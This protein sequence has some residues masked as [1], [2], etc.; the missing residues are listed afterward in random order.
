MS[1]PT[2]DRSLEREIEWDCQRVL[3]R[4]YDEFD[5]GNYAAM[6]A[7]FADGGVWHRAGKALAKEQIAAELR[8]RPSRQR[9]RHVLTNI[10]VEARDRD[11]ADARCYLTVYRNPDLDRSP[12]QQ[13]L[14]APYL[15][16]QVTARLERHAGTWSLREQVMQREFEFVDE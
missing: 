6:V 2:M 16:L 3:L 8:L 7:M 10:L 11:H 13:R 12:E 4:F 14:R 5:R 9:V 1:A 15:F